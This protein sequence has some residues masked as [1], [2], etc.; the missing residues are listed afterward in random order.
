MTVTQAPSARMTALTAWSKM[1]AVRAQLR[2]DIATG[3]DVQLIAA[4]KTAILSLQ[5]QIAHS[6]TRIDVLV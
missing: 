6:A 1:Q 2:A 4:D 3:A 5:Q